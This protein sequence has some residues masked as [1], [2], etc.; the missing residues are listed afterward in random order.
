MTPWKMPNQKP[1]EGVMVLVE[2]RNEYRVLSRVWFGNS[3]VKWFDST[4]NEYV[5]DDD[6][7]CWMEIPPSGVEA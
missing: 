5:D 2:T 6:V 1:P 4:S 3:V 7:L